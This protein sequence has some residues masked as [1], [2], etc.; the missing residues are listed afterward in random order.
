[1]RNSTIDVL[2]AARRV[3]DFAMEE[4]VLFSRSVSRPVCHHMGAVIADS[5]LQ[6]GLNYNTVVLPRVSNI[7]RSFPHMDR[8]S[9]LVKLID[10]G[11]AGQFLGW[12]HPEKLG[13]FER[14]V[15]FMHIQQ[16]DLVEDLKEKLCSGSFRLEL[17]SLNGIG[18]K[19]IDYLGCLVGVD[20]IAVDRHIRD[21][22]NQAGLQN[23]GYH[24]LHSVFC[25]AADLLEISR[26]DFD[27]WVWRRESTAH[28]YSLAL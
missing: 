1:M 9:M 28:Q 11:K 14:V 19:T 16:V 6:S 13:R 4:G 5:I 23:E 26:R 27:A 21:F 24:F 7:L 18:P 3:A 22:A 8:T 2:I 25:C 15:Q 12:S 10:Q 20:S 17:Q